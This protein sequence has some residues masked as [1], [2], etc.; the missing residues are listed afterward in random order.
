M[1]V[2]ACLVWHAWSGM[3]ADT[4][5]DVLHAVQLLEMHVILRMFH[6]CPQGR[7]GMAHAF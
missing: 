2:L 3:P 1:P 4:C 7:T 6:A 5:H